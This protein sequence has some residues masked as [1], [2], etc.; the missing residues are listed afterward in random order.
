MAGRATS[1]KIRGGG[2]VLDRVQDRLAEDAR[3]NA[4][5]LLT[6]GRVVTFTFVAGALTQDVPHGLDRR[7]R[8]FLVLRSVPTVLG[9]SPTIVEDTTVATP[10]DPAIFIRL[11]ASAAST[12][13]MWIV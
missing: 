12:A 7:F 11:T 13:T 5:I 9:A 3:A 6:N 1:P 2:E 8:G 4:R 10:P